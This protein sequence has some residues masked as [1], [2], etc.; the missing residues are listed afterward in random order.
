[1][2]QNDSPQADHVKQIQ[3]GLI[4]EAS[5]DERVVALRPALVRSLD[6]DVALA[7]LWQQ[8]IFRE[9]REKGVEQFEDDDG[10]GWWTDCTRAEIAASIGISEPQARRLIDKAR[11]RS[12]IETRQPFLARHDRR[13]FVRLN[14]LSPDRGDGIGPSAVTESAP[15]ADLGYPVEAPGHVEGTE[16]APLP[17][18]GFREVLKEEN[19]ARDSFEAF[20]S[21]YPRRNG[22]ERGSKKTARAIWDRLKPVDREAAM[23]GAVNYAAGQDPMFVKDAH[24]WLRDGLWVDWAEPRARRSK[25]GDRSNYRGPAGLAPEHPPT[26]EET[27]RW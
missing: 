5:D 14:R 13:L 25:P 19:T 23:V 2:S 8:L 16:S 27:E 24:R 21:T 18:E 7:A 4:W 10:Q 15:R 26:R 3:L 22:H 17:I 11:E 1:M 6:G 9:N 12:M 20:W